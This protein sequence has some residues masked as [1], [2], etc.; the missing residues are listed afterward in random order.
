MRPPGPSEGARPPRP[1]EDGPLGFDDR[2]V[3]HPPVEQEHSGAG[4]GGLVE[5]LH[6]PPGVSDLPVRRRVDLVD[7]P[8]LVRMQEELAG[9]AEA[10]ALAGLWIYEDLWVKAG[11][12]VPLS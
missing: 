8:N 7:E 5:G 12:S 1:L 3:D 4:G 11:Q 2:E 10:L 6:D 9:E